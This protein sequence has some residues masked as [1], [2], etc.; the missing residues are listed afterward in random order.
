MPED[1]AVVGVDNDPLVCDFCDPPLTSVSRNDYQ[2]GYEAAR[3]LDQLMEGVAPPDKPTRIPPAGVV[4]RR[5]TDTICV[6][7]PYV[8]EAIRYMREHVNEQ[9]GVDEVLNQLPLSRRSLEYRFRACLGR[10]PY[11]YLNQIRCRSGQAIAFRP[12]SLVAY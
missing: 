12:A 3:L 7:D 10:S 11:D 9:F 6:E 4:P 5:S 1:V 2:V 8:A